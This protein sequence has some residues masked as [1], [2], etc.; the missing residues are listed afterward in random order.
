MDM[1]PVQGRRLE[2][3]VVTY[4]LAAANNEIYNLV[5]SLKGRVSSL[6]RYR[7]PNNAFFIS[8]IGIGKQVNEGR[9]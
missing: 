5:F 3:L 7:P 6:H 4:K 1:K 2:D 9:G 8:L